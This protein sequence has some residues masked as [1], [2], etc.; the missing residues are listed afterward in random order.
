LSISF[1]AIAANPGTGGSVRK[2][3]SCSVIATTAQMFSGVGAISSAA[4]AA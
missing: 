1:Q 4:N 3:D 2:V